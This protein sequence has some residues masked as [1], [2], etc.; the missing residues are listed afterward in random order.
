MIIKLGECDLPLVLDYRHRMMVEAGGDHLL[1]DDWREVTHDHYS[2]GYR[3]GSCVH[4]GWREEG[5]IVAT[6]GALIRDD[7]PFFSFKARRYG[8]I[9]D[10][11]VL[12][13]YRRRGLASSLTQRTIDWLRSKGIVVARLTASDEARR[14][15]LYERMGFSFTNEMRLRLDEAS[16]AESKD[17]GASSAAFQT[18]AHSLRLPRV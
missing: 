4:F 17:L 13:E 1:A 6:T 10:V 12:P 2:Q 18:D 3:N 5:C 16:P 11:Y 14:T 9:M 15:G 7:F 8:W